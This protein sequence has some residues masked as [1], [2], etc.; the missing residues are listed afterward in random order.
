MT[1][2]D[3]WRPFE[4]GNLCAAQSALET[5]E[6]DPDVPRWLVAMWRACLVQRAGFTGAA[7]GL[8]FLAS[9][10]AAA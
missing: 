8:Y 5:A 2:D 7:R 6:D 3:F 10:R 1:D 9:L 4:A